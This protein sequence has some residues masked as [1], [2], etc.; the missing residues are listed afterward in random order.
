MSGR[1]PPT[2]ALPFPAPHT[3]LRLLDFQTDGALWPTRAQTRFVEAAGLRF[4][5]L[6]E[7]DGPD[8]LLIHGVGGSMHGWAPLLPHLTPHFRVTALDLP[9][10][11]FTQIPEDD[12]LSLEGMSE[13]VSAL[14]EALG[15][16]PKVVLGHSAGAGLG[17][18]LILDGRIVPELLLGV[19]PSLVPP[20]RMPM[21]PI[22]EKLAR[23]FVR[24]NAVAAFWAKFG[25]VEWVVR[26]MV[27]STGSRIPAEQ[28]ACY[29]RIAAHSG[30]IHAALT[31][32]SNWRPELLSRRFDEL[33]QRV[34][35]IGLMA[36]ERD[37]WIP[38]EEIRGVAAR[39]PGSRLV[40]LPAGHLA[41][42]ETPA[43]IARLVRSAW[44]SRR[45]GA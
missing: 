33:A 31:M 28:F 29:R 5:C 13:D 30:P 11:G 1:L 6:R 10:H 17:A 38:A 4:A 26:K 3:S 34:P 20:T 19:N 21:P 41:P 2:S 23:P 14:L 18:K 8:L 25:S 39:L 40:M 36:G 37:E 7:G 9:G 43:D 42:E 12:R 15:V 27:D 16:A 22:V 24:A 32:M 35:V 44:S 45:A